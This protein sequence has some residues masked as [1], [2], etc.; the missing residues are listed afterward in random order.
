MSSTVLRSLSRVFGTV[1]F[2]AVL[3]SVV[4][5]MP[6]MAEDYP[7]INEMLEKGQ[8]DPSLAE[9]GVLP[10]VPEEFPPDGPAALAPEPKPAQPVQSAVAPAPVTPS[11]YPFAGKV[12]QIGR[13]PYISVKGM[14]MAVGGLIS[15]LRQEMGVKDVRLVTPKDYAGVLTALEKGTIDFAWLGPTAYVIG[16]EKMRLIP[17]AKARRRTGITYRGILVTRKD[18]GITNLAQVKGRT[19]G[20]VDPESASGYLYPLDVL[21]KAGIDPHKDCAKVE[22]LQKHD[23][24]MTAV[25]NKKV[26]V[27]AVI[28]DTLPA[29]KDP[30][31]YDQ[32]EILGKTVEIPT[33][34]VACREDCDPALRDRFKAALLRTSSLKQKPL[35]TSGLP[36]VMEFLQVNPSE[37][38][39]VKA[40]LKGL[41]LLK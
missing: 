41:Q 1:L 6:A 14:M 9:D 17:L 24:V 13:P 39:S 5:V 36:P 10:E 16:A 32:I 20:F 26:D 25:W 2:L 8:I 19:I 34:I 21:R 40:F 35:A 31:V 15:F 4:P 29:I 27:G 23:A 33:D 28:E 12:V 38:E 37:I 30:K 11:S 22:F 3:A 7:T 18:S